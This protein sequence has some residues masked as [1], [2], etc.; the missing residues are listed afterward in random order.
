MIGR[1][2]L[3]NHV[4]DWVTQAGITAVELEEEKMT[5]QD[6]FVYGWDAVKEIIGRVWIYVILGIAVG[7]G[8]HGFVPEGV[9]GLAYGQRC[10]VVRAGIRNHRGAHV[11]QCGRCHSRG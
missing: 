6:R 8:I 7:A 10:L 9:M 3:E 5:W 1:L 2:K 4:E 11:F